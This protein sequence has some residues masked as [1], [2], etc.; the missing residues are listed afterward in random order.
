VTSQSISKA[1]MLEKN[2]KVVFHFVAFNRLIYFLVERESIGET[3]TPRSPPYE[4]ICNVF[5]IYHCG[6]DK[7]NNNN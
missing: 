4:Q 5:P 6:C 2:K 1:A 7:K 3:F